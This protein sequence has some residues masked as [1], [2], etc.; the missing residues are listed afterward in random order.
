MM[1]ALYF[2]FGRV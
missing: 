1:F 2:W